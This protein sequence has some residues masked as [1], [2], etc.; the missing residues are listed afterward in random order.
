VR[1]N[2][3]SAGD[4]EIRATLWWLLAHRDRAISGED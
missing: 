3:A 1:T 4:T 2:V